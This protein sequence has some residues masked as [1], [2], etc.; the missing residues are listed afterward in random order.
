MLDQ[1][2]G[3]RPSIDA[4]CSS[5]RKITNYGVSLLTFNNLIVKYRGA[6]SV[7]LKIKGGVRKLLTTNLSRAGGKD[8]YAGTL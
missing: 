4:S 3:E 5:P 1:I 7:T 2:Y 8:I 6:S